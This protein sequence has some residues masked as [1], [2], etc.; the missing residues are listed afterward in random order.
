MHTF[1]GYALCSLYAFFLFN[2]S[3]SQ[4][5]HLHITSAQ[6][7]GFFCSHIRECVFSF[8]SRKCFCSGLCGGTTFQSARS[9]A[10][11]QHCAMY[12]L[13]PKVHRASHYV[14][15]FESIWWSSSH[16]SV[17]CVQCCAMCCAVLCPMIDSSFLLGC[18][19]KQCAAT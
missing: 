4:L 16:L 18:L 1:L 6:C 11:R 10:A 9:T 15:C 19:W 3:Q 17:V 8:C 12:L 14:P 13:P 7:S 2:Y 5:S